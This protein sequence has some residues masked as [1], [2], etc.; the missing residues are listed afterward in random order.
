M[1][2]Q[3]QRRSLWGQ[4]SQ[5][6]RVNK[7]SDKGVILYT[8]MIPHFDDD[9]RMD[10]DPEDVKFNIV[11]RRNMTV[12]EVINQLQ[13]MDNLG[14]IIWYLVDGK[15]Y[16][17]M[18]PAAWE[19]HQIFKGI[20]RQPS[21]I[22]AYDKNTHQKYNNLNGLPEGCPH[23]PHRVTP[24]TPQGDRGHQIRPQEKRREEKR[25]IFDRSTVGW[26]FRTEKRTD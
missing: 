18:D 9:G 2:R 26:F 3:R 8:W 22:P 25:S 15:P 7:L 4:I 24:H 10:G 20:K 17:Q 16:I 5:S 19:S 23:T 12:E 13:L 11:P 6:N 1:Y 14:L 21:K